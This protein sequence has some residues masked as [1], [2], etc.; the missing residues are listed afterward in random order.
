[1]SFP[2]PRTNPRIQNYIPR[3][4]LKRSAKIFKKMYYLIKPQSMVGIE[5]ARWDLGLGI[6]NCAFA[7]GN[8][9]ERGIRL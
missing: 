5:Y 4:K 1:M 2:I 9:T 7:E 8:I 3:E 6:L